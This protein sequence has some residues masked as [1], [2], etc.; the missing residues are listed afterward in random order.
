MAALPLNLSRAAPAPAPAANTW[1]AVSAPDTRQRMGGQPERALSQSWTSGSTCKGS[2]WRSPPR[3]A[4]RTHCPPPPPD[5]RT[6]V[7]SAGTSH[8]DI[9]G[10]CCMMSGHARSMSGDVEARCVGGSPGRCHPRR[11][12]APSGA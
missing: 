1:G 5:A 12:L 2:Q 4:P 9:Q 6:P 3:Q 11:L 10:T 8:C 7:V